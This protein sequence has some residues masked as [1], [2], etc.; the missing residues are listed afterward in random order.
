V[1]EVGFEDQL[2]VRVNR[3]RVASHRRGR[4]AEWGL[5]RV[6]VQLAAGRNEMVL[7][8]TTARREN[9]RPWAT[10]VRRRTTDGRPVAGVTALPLDD[11]PPTH[12]HWREPSPY[13]TEDAPTEAKE[14]PTV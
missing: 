2:E 9:W 14:P 3:R 11:L 13:A 5:E 4:P 8:Q 12:D 1:L 10:F 6:P 7:W